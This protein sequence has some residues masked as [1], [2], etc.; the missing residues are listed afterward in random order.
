MNQ[1]FRS[2]NKARVLL[3]TL[4]FAPDSV[5]T[6][7][8]MTDL[9]RQLKKL[10]HPVTV[11]T[12]TPHYNMDAASLA[13]QPMSKVWGGLLYRSEMDGVTVWHV[14]MPLKGERVG[15]RM[16]DYLRFHVVSLMFGVIRLS[17]YDIVIAPSPPLSIGVVGWLLALRRR[18]PFV[19][20]VQE[21]YP[22]FA[23][24]QGLMSNP[25]LIKAM[26]WLE[27]FVYGRSKRVV[28]ISE[29]F[30]RII[31][32]RA[33]ADEKLTVIPNFVDTELYRPLPRSNA[34]S[35]AH[36]LSKDF[37]VLYG[38]NIGLSQDWE[39]MLYAAKTL[40]HLPIKFVLVGDGAKGKWLEHEIKVQG[41]E[42][43][44]LML[45]YQSRET[46][47][48]INAASDIGTIP[49]KTDTTTDTFPSKIYTILACARSVIVS[50]D[51]DS[52]LNWL[53]TQA[54]CGRVVMPDDP[55]AYADAVR[56]AYEDRE[57]LPDEGQRGRLFIERE[58][59]KEVVA[60]KYDSLI[61]ELTGK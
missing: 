25:T 28:P 51:A 46:M 14:K 19:Y 5:S 59:S 9:V 45:G 15:A 20:N 26:Q 29:W 38:G 41:L 60:Q 7:Y 35:E 10:G 3:H 33:V 22:D 61:Q 23:I 11:L 17:A 43:N 47:P 18:A 37:V 52:E 53:I 58:Y 34:F 39:S 30:S 57:T 42:K 55:Q 32:Q 21:I 8:L 12:T 31:R 27:R 16:L 6:A 56:K 44:V 24:N 54:R 1:S 2:M 40:A 13:R 50:A 48:L 36:G 49:M 4:V